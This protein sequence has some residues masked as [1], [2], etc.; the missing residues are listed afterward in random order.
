MTA[1]GKI[2]AYTLFSGS[3]GNCIYI[4]DGKTEILIDAGVS[5][6]ALEQS[7]AAIG[8]SLARISTIFVTHEHI[9][10]IRALPVLER[11]YGIPIHMTAPSIA[12]AG[13]GSNMNLIPHEPL[14]SVSIG[15]MEVRSFATSHDSAA[16]VGY[17]IET[18]IGKIAVATDTGYI[19][20]K[21]AAE[22]KGARF[23]VLESN[24]DPDL[25]L[26][27]PYPPSLKQRILSY[28]GHLSNADCARIAR[29]LADEGAERILLAHLSKE[30][31]TPS[32]AL[33]ASAACLAQGRYATELAVACRKEPTELIHP[34][35]NQNAQTKEMLS[36]S[37][38][39]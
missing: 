4:S 20:R 35:Q 34:P 27:G 19:S 14:F 2:A 18:E 31:N 23:V 24:Y 28:T 15:N 12:A 21:M 29:Y 17:L 32:L 5:T 13:F 33:E 1:H 30:N 8:S 11:K 6:R 3:D 7:L 22:L 37:S 10:H 38:L 39:T 25:L 26:R 16:G 36:C 9:D